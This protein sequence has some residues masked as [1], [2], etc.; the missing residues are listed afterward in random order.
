[1][2]IKHF[3]CWHPITN[4][5]LHLSLLPPQLRSNP[6]IV[7]TVW[8][9]EMEVTN[10]EALEE[11]VRWKKG[12]FRSS[13]LN[14][15]QSGEHHTR[16]SLSGQARYN[17]T[18]WQLL[19]PTEI[20]FSPTTYQ[21]MVHLTSDRERKSCYFVLFSLAWHYNTVAGFQ[22]KSTYITQTVPHPYNSWHC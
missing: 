15:E 3:L 11:R 4:Q 21:F 5:V 2:D 1:M 8:R 18:S 7:V 9:K 17:K 20:I 22:G 19:N 6:Q 13:D 10:V 16:A 14:S 12:H